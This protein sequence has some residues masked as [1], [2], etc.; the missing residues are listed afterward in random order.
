MKCLN[1]HFFSES[2]QTML[3]NLQQI[4]ASVWVIA[5]LL[6]VITSL[7]VFYLRRRKFRISKLEVTTGPVKTVLEPEK[8]EKNTIVKSQPQLQPNAINIR[9]NKLIGWNILRIRR[10]ATHVE[11]NLLVGENQ[12]E[13]G[14][15]PGPKPKQKR[16]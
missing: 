2:K 4:S 9:G 15:K 7:V 14:D 11:E 8:S 6:I 12:I 3:T 13:V 5:I 1:E 16:G 10:Q